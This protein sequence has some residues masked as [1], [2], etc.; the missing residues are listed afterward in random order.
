MSASLFKR[1]GF[2]IWIWMPTYFGVCSLSLVSAFKWIAIGNRVESVY[3]YS[4]TGFR[5]PAVR[6]LT[7]G[8]CW[9]PESVVIFVKFGSL[10]EAILKAPH[11]GWSVSKSSSVD[12]SSVALVAA[13]ELNVRLRIPCSKDAASAD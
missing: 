2:W 4:S 8:F 13:V 5:V 6:F 1:H 11:P 7:V 12:K 10:N 9:R 3:V